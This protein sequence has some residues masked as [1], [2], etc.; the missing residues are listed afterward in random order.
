MNCAAGHLNK[1]IIQ[2]E[3]RDQAKSE[4]LSNMSHDIR[5]PMNAIIGF[6][7]LALQ[8]PDDPEQMRE[9][10]EKIKASGDHLLS[11]INDVL[12]MSRI[13]SGRLE[14]R[15]ETV[16]LPKLMADFRTILSGQ[17]EQKHHTLNVTC[18]VE[19]PGVV[20]DKLRLNQV[21]LNL[22][23]N[24]V[25]YTPDGGVID[26]TLR[27]LEAAQDGKAPYEL[28]VKDNGIG[29]TPEF[30]ERIFEAFERAGNSTISGIQGTGLGMTITKNII[31][32][33]GGTITLETQEHKGTQF[34]VTLTLPVAALP[35]APEIT[36]TAPV[37]EKKEE[38]TRILVVDDVM[39]NRQLA[40]AILKMEH[41]ETEEAENG[42]IAVQ[43]IT[44]APAGYYSAVLMDIQM[45][46]MNGHIAKPIDR[47]QMVAAVKAV[48]N[49]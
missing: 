25:K 15:E 29:M 6:T 44:D 11:L 9:H 42:E 19:D 10:L 39:M 45:P 40:A 26:I 8:N 48:L 37:T 27:Q 35:A 7:D 46:V 32:K 43:R 41:F 5:T 18:K 20:C 33:M 3:E 14:F 16:D 17:A 34:L 28:R 30:A 21:L 36:E 38:T 47:E 23:S 22:G 2:A 4:F 24:A 31:D 1:Q 13:E 49:G 12:E